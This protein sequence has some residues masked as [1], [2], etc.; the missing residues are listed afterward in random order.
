MSVSD[1]G[2]GIRGEDI[3]RLFR[4]FEQ[5]DTKANKGKEGTGLGLTIS[6]ELIRMMGGKLEVRSE[7]GRGS[8]FFFSIYQKTVSGALE[9]T[10]E[11]EAESMDFTAPGAR[12]LIVDDYEMNLKVAVGLLAP[13]QMQIELAESGQKALEMIQQKKYHMVFMDHMMPGMDGVETTLRLRKL[14]DAYYQELPVIA[15]TANAMKEAEKLFMESGMN[16]FVAKPID[17]RQICAVIRKW[18]PEELLIRQEHTEQGGCSAEKEQESGQME[19]PVLEGIDNEEG[20]RNAG[21]P[22]MFVSLLG[23]YYKLID[24]KSK[25]VEQCVADTQIREYTIEVHALKSAS[26]MIG[27]MALAERFLRLEQL[28]NAEDVEAIRRETP[29]VLEL[30]RKYQEILKPYG[31][32]QESEKQQ[33]STEEVLECIH[34][35]REAA[36]E[37]DIDAADEAM[38]CLEKCQLPEVCQELMKNLQACVVNLAMDE[39]LNITDEMMAILQ[40]GE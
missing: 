5:V 3:Q 2:Q 22:A 31:E 20:I 12:I 13:L 34:K 37:F 27:A 40:N 33:V 26:K 24:I 28:G 6:S 18:L 11:T 10:E 23:D 9:K 39:V 1:T 35:I 7:Y 25:K 19:L 36:E 32:I 30:Y 16:G 4:S 17:M 21:G 38:N 15:L 8:E 29:E 14:P